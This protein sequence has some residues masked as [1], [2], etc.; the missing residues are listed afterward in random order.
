MSHGQILLCV[1]TTMKDGSVPV[2]NTDCSAF[3]QP[4]R[5]NREPSHVFLGIIFLFFVV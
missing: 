3:L 4:S 1:R 2:R 5:K